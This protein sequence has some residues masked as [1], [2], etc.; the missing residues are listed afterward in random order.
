MTATVGARRRRRRG[1]PVR[2]IARD[3]YQFV[4]PDVA[5][6]IV[7]LATAGPHAELAARFVRARQPRRVDVRLEPGRPRAARARRRGA[8]RRRQPRRRRGGVAGAQR[9]VRPPPGERPRRLRRA[10]RRRAR[11]GRA[12]VRPRAPPRPARAGRSAGRTA[13]G[14]SGRRAAGA[15]CAGS[16]SRSGR[17]TATAARCPTR[18]CCTAASPTSRG[19]ARG[20]RRRGATGSR[21]RLPMLSPPHREGGVGAL[22]VEARG[23]E[24][25]GG[26]GRPAS[27]AWPS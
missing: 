2:S 19:S 22:R 3:R 9:A 6:P 8:R 5:A 26:A 18:G 25:A 10:A 7:V 15:S 24:D 21:P 20:A 12:G 16:P 13:R 4:P 27:S 17:A 14:S 23:H 1:R 11:H